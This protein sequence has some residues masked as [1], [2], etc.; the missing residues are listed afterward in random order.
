MIALWL[1]VMLVTGETI[2]TP[3]PAAQCAAIAKQ[4]IQYRQVT[5]AW[6]EDQ[7]SMRPVFTTVS[8]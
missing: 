5:T 6:C 7:Q 8:M 3:V 1:V 4:V 2:K